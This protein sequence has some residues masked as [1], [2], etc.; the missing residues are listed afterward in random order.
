MRYTLLTGVA[1]LFAAAAPAAAQDMASDPAAQ[2]TGYEQ[3][4]VQT[5]P[6][7]VT[8][9]APF[10]GLY[11]GG[12]FGYDVQGNDVGSSILFDNGLNGGFGDTVR[13]AAGAN[14]FSTGFCNGAG[15]SAIAPQNGGRCRNDRDDIAYYARV[16]F[17]AQV[18]FGNVGVVGEFGKS[19][20]SDSVTAFSTTPANYVMT[21]EVEWEA[22]IRGRAGF[23]AG[24]STLFYGAFGPGYISLDR[25]F[26]STNTAN[27][28][29]QR[30]KKRQF[31]VTG[32]GGVEQMIGNNFAIGLEYMYHQYEDDDARV[33]VSQGTAGAT[34]PFVLAGGVD[35][36]RSDEKF[37]W[38]SLR[39]TAG[40]RF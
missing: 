8:E 16:G 17:D 21:R 11:V 18:G 5:T 30:G 14:A 33:R 2:S 13:T 35:F 19:E 32:G 37:R 12:S 31:G 28:F 38:H 34:N 10:T 36:R 4:A 22:S 26:S 25:S 6:D 40:F 24:K 9:R 1:A 7:P 23:V 39:A 20:I 3:P 15:T 27:A 29:A